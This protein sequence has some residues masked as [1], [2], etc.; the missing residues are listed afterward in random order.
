MEGIDVGAGG[1]PVHHEGELG[2]LRAEPPSLEH[3]RPPGRVERPDVEI[4]VHGASI[5]FPVPS[6]C[7]L[8]AAT[9]SVALIIPAGVTV[10][11]LEIRRPGRLTRDDRALHFQV[12]R[13]DQPLPP[14]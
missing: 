4:V 13:L 1:L 9:R 12:Y 6:H 3:E 7:T 5:S 10:E 8:R 14:G 2:R 11:R